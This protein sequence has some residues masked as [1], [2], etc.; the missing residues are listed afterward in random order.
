M[1][2]DQSVVSSRRTQDWHFAVFPM[3]IDLHVQAGEHVK[4]LQ[5]LKLSSKVRQPFNHF[6]WW[7]QSMWSE[8]LQSHHTLEAATAH[9]A[10]PTRILF[11]RAL[12]THRSR[13]GSSTVRMDMK[14]HCGQRKV[15][16]SNSEQTTAFDPAAPSVHRPPPS[17]RTIRKRVNQSIHDI[18]VAQQLNQLRTLQL[19]GRWLDWSRHMHQDLSW[20]RLIHNWSDAQLR[21]ALQAT[22]DRALT[23][24][25]LRRWGVSKVDPACIMCGKPATLRSVLN[26]GCPVALHQGRY[27]WRHISVLS[28]IRHSLNT[29]WEQRSTQLAIQATVSTKEKARYIQF[30][31]AG[32][33][34]PAPNHIPQRKPLA[35]QAILLQAN[36][37]T[38]LYE[39][40][41]KLQFPIEPAVTSLRPDVVLFSRSSKT[42]ALLEP[43][44]RLEDNLHL[45]HDRKTTKYSAF[46]MA[47]KENGFKTH[48]FALEVGCLGYCPHSFLHCFE[49]LRLPKPAARQI[50]SK[51]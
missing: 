11:G 10:Q 2:G 38:F 50:R 5:D 41:G 39:L 46:V 12:P 4:R 6:C 16:I 7:P 14:V 20:Q 18:H 43:T 24:T 35:S 22:T 13:F 30:V 32:Q 48:L 37:W 25:N 27:T 33:R 49:A 44:V 42:V 36:D 15:I 34:L 8:G 47:C 19:W 28:A 23:A 9:Q 40:E 45:A 17:P 21:F 3:C 31:R 1:G 26:N 29:F 51:A